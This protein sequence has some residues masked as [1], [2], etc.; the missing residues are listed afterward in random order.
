MAH[1][2]PLAEMGRSL[3]KCQNLRWR[4]RGDLCVAEASSRFKEVEEGAGSDKEMKCRI[5]PDREA[6]G[7]CQKHEAGFCQECCECLNIDRCCECMDPML[8]C[9]F[10]T[11]CIIWELSRDRRKQ[12]IL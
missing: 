11:R 7:V 1:P 8:Y 3:F 2:W 6:I 5:H 12:E 10:R 9:K 4:C